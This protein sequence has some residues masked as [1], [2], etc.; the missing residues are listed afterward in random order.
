MCSFIQYLIL[1]LHSESPEVFVYSN[2]LFPLFY[3]GY[4]GG[5]LPAR[6]FNMTNMKNPWYS[7]YRNNIFNKVYRFF[8]CAF[9][10]KKDYSLRNNALFSLYRR[11]KRC[12][13]NVYYFLHDACKLQKELATKPMDTAL[14]FVL[15]VCLFWVFRTTRDFF[16]HME[17]W[18]WL[19]RGCKFDLCSAL[20][21]I[22][23]WGFLACHTYCNTGH[24]FIMVISEDLWHSHLLP[25][26][27]QWSSHYLFLRL[28][29][30]ATGI[31]TFNLPLA[32]LML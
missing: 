13:S 25:R 28:R 6:I 8:R 19:V 20:M 14:F 23:Q 11:F 10:A 4:S 12:A 16:T 26:V 27:W 17:T 3:H 5:K 21:A 22:E 7:Y 31:R 32:G 15:F 29:S 9:G 24:L 18:P 1:R 2:N 30:A